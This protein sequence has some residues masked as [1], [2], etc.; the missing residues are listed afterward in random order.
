MASQKVRWL[1][2]LGKEVWV[3][4]VIKSNQEVQGRGYQWASNTKDKRE[5]KDGEDSGDGRGWVSYW[6]V[7][8]INQGN[9]KISESKKH[10]KLEFEAAEK[11]KCQYLNVK[12]KFSVSNQIVVG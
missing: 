2:N 9:R 1:F 7:Y 5:N 3:K 10:G 11:S 4:I 12:K 8:K 6:V